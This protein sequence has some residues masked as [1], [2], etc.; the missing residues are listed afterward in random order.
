MV[1]HH[2]RYIEACKMKQSGQLV[3][4]EMKSKH[5]IIRKWP[6]ALRLKYGQPGAQE[7]FDDHLESGHQ[8]TERY[9]EWRA[10]SEVQLV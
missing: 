1:V 3:G 10:Q 4:M 6:L 7:E 5:S 8:G 9:V 2:I